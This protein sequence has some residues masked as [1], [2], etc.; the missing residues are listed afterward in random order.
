MSKRASYRHKKPKTKQSNIPKDLIGAVW[1]LPSYEAVTAML[2]EALRKQKYE[3]RPGSQVI[4]SSFMSM[5]DENGEYVVAI[6]LGFAFSGAF[7]AA[8]NMLAYKHGGAALP[9]EEKERKQ[10]LLAKTYPIWRKVL[11]QELKDSR[12]QERR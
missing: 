1:V 3:L 10:E 11:K 6:G 7:L 2:A 12:V 8:C 4:E 5:S 9:L